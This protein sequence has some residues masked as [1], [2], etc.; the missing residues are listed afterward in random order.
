MK[1]LSIGISHQTAPIE[2]RERLWFSEDE[3]RSALPKLKEKFFNECVLFSTCNRTELYGVTDSVETDVE[4]LRGFLT[5]LKQA[6]SFLQPEHFY[7]L[8]DEEAAKHLF[9]VTSGIESMMLGDVQILGQVRHAYQLAQEEKASGLLTSKLFQSALRTGKR[10]RTETEISEGAVSVSY[11]ATELAGRIYADLRKRTA[12]LVGAGK[13]SEL[14]LKHLR[15]KGVQR[16]LIANRTRSKAEELAKAF[17]AEVI[18]FDDLKHGLRHADILLTSVSSTGYVL[19]AADLTHSMKERGNRPLLILDMGVPRNI[20]PTANKIENIFLHDIDGLQ[21]IV[22]KNLEKRRGEIQK[23]ERIIAEE[24]DR[25]LR[26]QKSLH[27]N[28]TIEQL[29]AMAEEIRREEVEKHH[30]RFRP[31]ERETLEIVTK[32]I[33]NKL[34]HHPLSNLRNGEGERDEETLRMISTVRELFGLESR[35]NKAGSDDQGKGK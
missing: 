34:L 26:W 5:G 9:R 8:T 33:I 18:N 31:E 13:T 16:I 21:I 3:V 32:R 4:S 10:C 28:P 27:V 24:L 22:D 12:L 17:K 2:L 1:L 14:T 30:H 15:S 25:F 29:Q 23:V 11:G 19:S 7:H 6:D 20:D 35:G